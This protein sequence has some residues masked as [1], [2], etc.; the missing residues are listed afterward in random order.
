MSETKTPPGDIPSLYSLAAQGDGDAKVELIRL[1]QNYV[2]DTA[3]NLQAEH[4]T[5]IE[6]DDLLQEGTLGILNSLRSLSLDSQCPT[7]AAWIEKNIYAALLE[8]IRSE[9]RNVGHE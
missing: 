1:Y 9:L 7:Y 2:K 4:K 6:A 3:D 5:R 8:R